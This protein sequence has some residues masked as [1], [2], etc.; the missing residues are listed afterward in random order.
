MVKITGGKMRLVSVIGIIL[1]TPALCQTAAPRFDANAAAAIEDLLTKAA[2][3]NITVVPQPQGLVVNR[4][5]ISYK[6]PGESIVG[7]TADEILA[8]SQQDLGALPDS[9]VEP[10]MR[11]VEDA[12][13]A[14]QSP[15]T[16]VLVPATLQPCFEKPFKTGLRRVR[17]TRTFS[18]LDCLAALHSQSDNRG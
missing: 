3:Q 10:L 11:L 14:N 5:M 7:K 8:W 9:R 6:G 18:R 13:G 4:R 16:I 12:V 17:F 15:G 1:A 2:A